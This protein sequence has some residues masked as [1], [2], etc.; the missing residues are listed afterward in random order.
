M[1]VSAALG[2][3]LVAVCGMFYWYYNDSQETIG[4][5]R[6]NQ[7]KLETAIE[8]SEQSIATLQADI[9][10]NAELNRKLQKDLQQAEAYGDDLRAK[11]SKHN[12]TNLA[13]SKPA[14]LEEKMNNA[15]QKLWDGFVDD[16]TPADRVQPI[17]E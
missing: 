14:L 6:E 11:L 9:L 7:A 5:L 4:V 10:K 15:T 13:L 3:V 17:S 2:A 16:T 1:N 8:I 12:L